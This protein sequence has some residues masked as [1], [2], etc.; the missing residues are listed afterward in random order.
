MEIFFFI[1]LHGPAE[2]DERR[3]L[4]PI[5]GGHFAMKETRHPIV[6]SLLF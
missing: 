2:D 5:L 4:F 6:R 3:H 1:D